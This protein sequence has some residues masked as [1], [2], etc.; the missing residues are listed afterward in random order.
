MTLARDDAIED[1]E[2]SGVLV[3]NGRIN[4]GRETFPRRAWVASFAITGPLD[5][6]A[7]QAMIETLAGRYVEVIGAR[8]ILSLALSDIHELTTPK[9]A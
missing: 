4:H 5:S 3:A 8:E 6:V 1:P 2:N 9:C 7:Y